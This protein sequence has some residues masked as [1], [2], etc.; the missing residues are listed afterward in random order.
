MWS[1]GSR[2]LG[3]PHCPALSLD[4]R[5]GSDDQTVADRHPP[6]S[7]RPSSS[8]GR[9]GAVGMLAD[10]VVLDRDLLTVPTEEIHS[11]KVET[12]LVGGRVVWSQK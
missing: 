3:L 11:L 2:Q 5:T 4:W 10:L 9:P 1:A 12:T 6:S 7:P 8:A